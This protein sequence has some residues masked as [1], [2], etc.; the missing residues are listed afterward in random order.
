MQKGFCPQQVLNKNN[1]DNNVDYND[2]LE[3]KWYDEI[4]D[5]R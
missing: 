2:Q 4:T 5:S 1:Y 3:I